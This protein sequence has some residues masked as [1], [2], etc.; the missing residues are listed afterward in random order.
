MGVAAALPQVRDGSGSVPGK[1]DSAEP[2]NGGARPVD[3]AGVR[4]PGARRKR[5]TGG[6]ERAAATQGP[7]RLYCCV[8]WNHLL[9]TAA[10]GF[11]CPW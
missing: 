7:G 5:E 1:V 2:E 11:G 10:A 8:A 6:G 4:G 3:G 9:S